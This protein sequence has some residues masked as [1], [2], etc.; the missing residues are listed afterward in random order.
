MALKRSLLL[1]F[2]EIPKGAKPTGDT[3]VTENAEWVL[4]GDGFSELGQSNNAQTK[5]TQYINM[6][7]GSTTVTGYKP[8]MS[9]SVEYTGTQT[10]VN[11]PFKLDRATAYLDSIRYS[12]KVGA[13]V[14]LAHVDVFTGSYNEETGWSNCNTQ[15][16]KSNVQIDS[17]GGSAE[18]PI[19][20][21]G[22]FNIEGEPVLTTATVAKDKR[23]I[24]LAIA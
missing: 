14:R 11:A 16:F 18:D 6:D 24:T 19:T 8:T 13:Q 7:M 15:I 17:Y 9:F 23:G 4:C 21:E 20:V 1:T 5:D 22:Q 2:I 10:D 12:G 3:S